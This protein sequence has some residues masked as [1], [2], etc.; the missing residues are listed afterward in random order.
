MVD[1]IGVSLA[2][3]LLRRFDSLV[4]ERR[5]QNRSEAIRD[6]I[7]DALVKQDWQRGQKEAMGVA[8]LVYDHDM[9]DLARKLA[10][11]QHRHFAAVVATLHVHIDHRNCLEVAVLRGRA[12]DLARLAN[13]LISAKG[14]KH[15]QF[16]P[17]TTG[18]AIG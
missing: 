8:L 15:G 3:E 18:K 17:T 9:S 7:R 4:R 1:R 11:R 12:K 6:L 14:V 10:S 13:S 16:I 2:R 5:Y